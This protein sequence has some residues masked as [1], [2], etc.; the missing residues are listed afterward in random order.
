[1]IIA[2]HNE[3]MNSGKHSAKSMTGNYRGEGGGGAYI[4]KSNEVNSSLNEYSFG[5]ENNSK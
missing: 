5:I 3:L 1:M 2:D 4:D